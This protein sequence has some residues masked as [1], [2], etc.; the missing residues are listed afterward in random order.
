MHRV[1]H[2]SLR[3]TKVNTAATH[4]AQEYAALDLALNVLAEPE[5]WNQHA[6]RTISS[7]LLAHTYG[8][9]GRS[10]SALRFMSSVYNFMRRT[11]S[12]AS[13]GEWAVDFFPWLTVLPSWCA[14]WK[15]WAAGHYADSDAEFLNMAGVGSSKEEVRR[16]SIPSLLLVAD[17][18][19]HSR[20]PRAH[21]RHLYRRPSCQSGILRAS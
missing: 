7:A 13:P 1:A 4:A 10:E 11:I 19:L 9:P 18:W 16:S 15:A 5:R 2:E 8:V 14:T 6:R 20:E 17:R 21:L 3:R 12:S